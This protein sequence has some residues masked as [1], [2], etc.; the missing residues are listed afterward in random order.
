MSTNH[1][2]VRRGARSHNVLSMAVTLAAGFVAANS[3]AGPGDLASCTSLASLQIPNTT[4]T[5]ATFVAPTATLPGYCRVLA[6][7]AP[8][9]DIEV[10]LPDNYANRYLHFGGGGFDGR[11]PNL[12]GPAMSGGVNPLTLGMVAV[13]SNGG[14]RS[15]S[16]N[17]FTDQALVLN[18]ASQALQEAACRQG[19]GANVLWT[20]GTA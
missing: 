9:T 3:S 13:G 18:Y 12:D 7:V 19:R 5:L 4:I 14:H 11:I 10:R 20:A 17:F 8:Q 1:Y 6:T 15:S 16:G 2:G